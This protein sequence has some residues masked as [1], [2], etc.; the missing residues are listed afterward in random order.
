MIAKKKAKGVGMPASTPATDEYKVPMKTV[1]LPSLTT[2]INRKPATLASGVPPQL[3]VH[4]KRVPVPQTMTAMRR[5]P[6]MSQVNSQYGGNIENRIDQMQQ[7]IN[8]QQ[9]HIANYN[10]MKKARS[11][12]YQDSSMDKPIQVP[13]A[14][15]M[16]ES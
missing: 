8:H 11:S 9:Q 16:H 12:K 14:S 10:K 7:I 1:Y 2:A 3:L 5:Q 13:N 15:R 6:T 4:K